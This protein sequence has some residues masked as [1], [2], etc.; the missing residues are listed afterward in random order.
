MRKTLNRTLACFLSVALLVS[1]CISGLVLPAAAST[2]E[3]LFKD[4]GLEGETLVGTWNVDGTAAVTAGKGYNGSKGWEVFAGKYRSLPAPDG[5][6]SKTL[7][8]TKYYVLS[9]KASGSN[10]TFYSANAKYTQKEIKITS[11]E[12][13]WV[14]VQFEFQVQTGTTFTKLA[15]F[16]F[17]NNHTSATN[18]AYFDDFAVYEYDQSQGWEKGY[19]VNEVAG[20]PQNLFKDAGLE[21]ETLVGTWNVDGIAAVTDGKGFGGGKAWEVFAGK[22]RSLPAPDGAISKTMDPTKYYVLS[23]KASGSNITFHS[24]NAK[25]TQK[26]FNITSPENDWVQVQFEF[27]VQSGTT[28]TK[29]AEF[30]FIN[31]HTSTTNSAYFDDFAVYEYDQSQG[32]ADGYV[33]GEVGAVT[34][35][36]PPPSV[37]TP[38]DAEN[39]F[40]DAGLE[41]TLLGTNWEKD[42]IAT[43]KDGEGFGGG[44]AWEMFAGKETY[45]SADVGTLSKALAS[46]KYYVLSFK[47]KGGSVTFNSSNSNYTAA[48]FNISASEDWVEVKFEFQT[49]N[50]NDLDRLVGFYLKNNDT[51]SVYFDDFAVYEYDQSQGWADGYVVG[52][53]GA[54]TPPSPPPSVDTPT[55]TDNLFKDAGLE[56]TLLGTN[57]EKSGIATVVSGKGFGGGKAW[58]MFAEQQTY[59][60]ADAGTLSKN[61]D[62]TKYYVLSFKKKGGAV[63]FYS[64]NAAYTYALFDIPAADGWVELQF[65]F[66]TPDRNDLNRLVGFYLKNLDTANSVYFDDF[67]VYEYDASQGWADGYVI[68]EVTEPAPPSTTLDITQ[69]TATVEV[70]GAVTL[71]ATTTPPDATV[72]W[73]SSDD[74]IA[75]VVN[76]VV[77]GVKAGTVT[78]TATMGELTDTCQVTVTEPAPVGPSENLFLDA[79][80]EGDTLIG[81]W[82]VDG[83]AALA[84]GKGFGGGKAWEIFAN[85]QRNIPA[86]DNAISKTMEPGKYYV[87]FFKQTGGEAMFASSNPAYKN[88]VR[89]EYNFT[90][91]QDGWNEVI[92]PFQIDPT[93]AT[94]LTKLVEFALHNK[95][96]GSVYFDDFAVYEYT[97]GMNLVPGSDGA[98]FPITTNHNVYSMFGNFALSLD[99]DGDNAVWKFS[100]LGSAE[101]SKVLRLMHLQKLLTAGD[102]VEISFRFKGETAKLESLN[103][104]NAV[105]RSENT[106]AADANG[107]KTYTAT[108]KFNIVNED[109]LNSSLK[110]TF[111]N[112]TEMLVDDFY[113][114]Q[115]DSVDITEATSMVEIGQTVTL[116][117]TTNPAG[118]AITWIS[119]NDAVATVV[120][121]VVTGISKGTVTITAAISGGKTDTCEVKV[122]DVIPNADSLKMSHTT[123]YLAPGAFRTLS[124]LAVPAGNKIGTITFTSERPEVAT[125]DQNGKVTAVADGETL[126]TATSSLGESLVATCL[127]KVDKYGDIMIGGDFESDTNTDNW[128]AFSS[129]YAQF[130]LDPMEENSTNH[131]LNVKPTGV[132]RFYRFYGLLKSNTVYRLTGK[133]RGDAKAQI[134]LNGA[135]EKIVGSGEY[136]PLTSSDDVTKWKEFELVFLTKEGVDN[137][138]FLSLYNNGQG[139]VYFDD[140]KMQQTTVQPT[141]FTMDETAE[142]GVGVTT[143]LKFTPKPIYADLSA[144]Q[145]SSSDTS[146][147]TV[148]STG[149]ITTLKAGKTTI[150]MKTTDEVSA[151]CELTVTSEARSFTLSKQSLALLPGS[152][153]TLYTISDPIGATIPGTLAWSSSDNAVATV[154]NGVVTAVANGTATITCTNGTLSAT[155]A[156][157]VSENGELLVGGDFQNNTQ[158]WANVADGTNAAIVDDPY[159]FGNKVLVINPEK[160]TGAYS[161]LT[162]E[163]DTLYMLTLRAR[164]EDATVSINSDIVEKLYTT[165]NGEKTVKDPLNWNDFTIRFRT[166]AAG[167]LSDVLSFV[168][169]D[170]AETYIDDVSLVKLPA[171]TGIAWQYQE[172][173]TQEVAPDNYVQLSV[174]PIPSDAFFETPVEWSVADT[175]IATV[176]KYGEIRGEK[177]G[178]TTVTASFPG[179]A[180]I[181]L[182]IK[183]DKYAP[184][185]SEGDFANPDSKW[186]APVSAGGITAGAAEDGS[187][188]FVLSTDKHMYYKGSPV[189]LV[190]GNSYTMT[191]R[192]KSNFKTSNVLF[193]HYEGIARMNL[194]NTNG[195]WTTLTVTKTL[196]PTYKY[197]YGYALCIGADVPVTA[198][199]GVVIDSIDIRLADSGVDAESVTLSPNEKQL[200]TG[201]SVNLVMVPKPD[202]ANVNFTIWTSSNEDVAIV[203]NGRVFGVGPGTATI[204]AK[205][206]LS[207][208]GFKEDTATITVAGEGEALIKNG[209]FDNATDTSWQLANGATIEAQGYDGTNSVYFDNAGESATQLVKG[210]KPGSSYS[211]RFRHMGTVKTRSV[212]IRV[213]KADGSATYL[214]ETF[215]SNTAWNETTFTFSLPSTS[216]TEVI[217][218]AVSGTSEHGDEGYILLDNIFMA[219]GFSNADLIASDIL[220]NDGETQMKPGTPVNFTA[221]IANVGTED[222]KDTQ[223]I[224]VELRANAKTIYTWTYKGGV[225][226]QELAVL[227]TDPDKPW[228]A[229]EGEWVLSLHVNTTGT[230]RESN[231]LNNGIQANIRVADEFLVAPQQALNGGFNKLVFSDDFTTLDTIDGGFTGDYGYNWYFKD[232]TGVSGD[233]SDVW[234]TEDGIMLAGKRM[235]YNSLLSTLDSTTGA[236]W[237]GFTHGYLEYR[238]RFKLDYSTEVTSIAGAPAVWSFQ[239]KYFAP[240]IFGKPEKNVEVDWMEYW[241]EKFPQGNWTITLHESSVAADGSL[242]D[243][244][245]N[246]GTN[247]VPDSKTGQENDIGDGEWH[248]IGYRWNEGLIICYLDGS[249]VWRQEWGGEYGPE[250]PVNGKYDEDLFKYIDEQ[251]LALF[252]SGGS[253]HP[254]ELDYIRVWQSDGTLEEKPVLDNTFLDDHLT[255]EDGEYF[256]EVTADNYQAILDALSDW[257]DLEDGQRDA[258]NNVLVEMGG[259]TYDELLYEAQEA[260]NTAEGFVAYYACD[261]YGDA[262]TVVDETNYEWILGSEEEWM[263][264]SDLERAIINDLVS[265]L[266]GMTFDEMLEAAAA[267]ESTGEGESGDGD[268]SGDGNE[269]G[270]GEG[271]S[272]EEIPSPEDGVPFPTMAV[273]GLFLGGAAMI[274]GKKRRD[275]EQE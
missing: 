158:N 156:V 227:T 135:A 111:G 166:K 112:A 221:V 189:M 7:D 174:A 240:K 168:G 185:F 218:E 32:W 196:A 159:E 234:L 231:M 74:T 237:S 249:E 169:G 31:E 151:S 173:D 43:V 261:E 12:N 167:T 8:P 110:L 85:K 184:L 17:Y 188:G 233:L 51:A 11:P 258:I 29:L 67:A 186:W 266:C 97:K 40:K 109:V 236:G 215:T 139:Q 255:G 3:N 78:I 254:M 134:L 94:G 178:T 70:G 216:G 260:Y 142:L 137:T 194:N 214:Q 37:D 183:V 52:E 35:P 61:L 253:I 83:I 208:G 252:I 179:L 101:L 96:T 128:I 270:D 275:E 152:A 130:M 127:V 126:I 132:Q 193:V 69:S 123:L 204:T 117:A 269:S 9:F 136:Y 259:K 155:C 23:F 217:L 245:S 222:I 90:S 106:S 201:E 41:G 115:V 122:V 146:V 107:W 4:A 5:A 86:P 205:V 203:E 153:A 15:E 262:Y 272:E 68:K 164:G 113:L 88:F 73:I 133:V 58:E 108:V 77:T 224:V 138:Y 2:P 247:F 177:E 75:T 54:V 121:G 202:N 63:T 59:I 120:N 144:V 213:K 181:T 171:L 118:K 250:P 149:K 13:G 210:V 34:P 22:R 257:L 18:S 154:N 219:E 246:N 27:Q 162:L 16:Y 268:E 143:K 93:R 39:L 248:T 119:S 105:I 161:N 66:Q 45:I 191:V 223:E 131:V 89:G 180:P 92:I 42:G 102:E 251:N 98:T 244:S 125:V 200:M 25:Y 238:T 220:F 197:N 10:L 30:Y 145:W 100:D 263:S 273:V 160:T 241:G 129:N 44:K 170:D 225:K 80:L 264:L 229:E 239:D 195:E 182:N 50:R 71:T 28:F 21:G 57:W 103:T 187:N 47:K 49:P 65:E 38:T 114:G 175:S 62:S 104:V 14:E 165:D 79:G 24:A 91:P 56:G 116:N 72:T 199:D 84:D 124:A 172:G 46:T 274:A 157:K 256:T 235:R 87:L 141:A 140:I 228:I 206:P 147:A 60:S 20:P 36:S 81:T 53:V 242:Y 207:N 243:Q 212:T 198:A 6:I 76:G 211:L 48:L 267:F 232:M 163:A 209:T 271:S 265:E 55:D 19:V 26:Q 190:P 192:Y 176:D 150:T 95:A 33:V 1:C 148:D 64:S 226:K 99:K 82:N 230:V